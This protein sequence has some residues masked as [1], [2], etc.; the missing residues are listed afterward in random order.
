MS[1]RLE[2]ASGAASQQQQYDMA[3]QR[4]RS[5]SS[6]RASTG[7]QQEEEVWTPEEYLSQL[8]I[9]LESKASDLFDGRSTLQ[10]HPRGLEYVNSKLATLNRLSDL[11]RSAEQNTIDYMRA[12]VSGINDHQ[13]LERIQGTLSRLSRVKL[14]SLSKLQRDPTPIDLTQFK[15]LTSLEIYKCDLST[16]PVSGLAELRPRLERLI[17]SNSAEALQ[18]IFAPRVQKR[19]LASDGGHGGDG[20]QSSPSLSAEAGGAGEEGSIPLTP[21]DRSSGGGP[22]DYGEDAPREWRK[23]ETVK[24]SHN[25]CS[26]MDASLTLLTCVRSLDLSSNC[27]KT[28]ENLHNCVNLMSLDLSSNRISSTARLN[29]RCGNLTVLK[30][31]CNSLTS[32][33]GIDK[34]YSLEVLDLSGNLISKFSEISRLGALPCLEELWLKENPVFYASK[35]VDSPALT[36]FFA[37]PSPSFSHIR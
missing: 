14:M 32:I 21:D 9:F 23:L 5:S 19:A 20:A 11:N 30:L 27:F 13:R 35:Y 16:H 2:G 18:H 34:L 10:L 12:Y 25:S 33:E 15:F 26:K 37:P 24:C 7:A 6:S 8:E 22:G 1:G 17:V 29:E 28:M 4:R 3:R 31:K 36:S